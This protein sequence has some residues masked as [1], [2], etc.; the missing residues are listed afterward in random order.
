MHAVLALLLVLSGAAS[1]MYQIAWTRRVMSLTSAT[2]TAQALVVA[3]FM[4]GLGAGAAIAGRSTP[5]LRRPLLAYAACEAVAAIFA[6]LSLPLISALELPLFAV[7]LLLFCAATLI[8]A[9]LPFAIDHAERWIQDPAK[10][11]RTI[12]ILYGSNTLG[13]AFGALTA[14]FATVERFGLHA[15]TLLGAS[16]AGMAA[17]TAVLISRSPPPS[18]RFSPGA[19]AAAKG[20]LIAAA[21]LLGLAGVGA[22]IVYTRLFALILYNTVYAFA[23]VLAAVLIGIA[24]GGYLA[25]AATRAR[26]PIISTTIAFASAA[27]VLIAAS[28]TLV[29]AVAHTDALNASLA[30]GTFAGAGMALL[31]I[32]IPSALVASALPLL[33]AASTNDR[34]AT[35]FGWLYAANTLGGVAGSLLVGFALLPGLGLAPTVALIAACALAAGSILLNTRDR[36]QILLLAF[37]AVTIVVLHFSRDVPKEIYRARIPSDASILDFDEGVVSDAMVTEDARGHRRLWINSAWVAGTGGGHRVLGHLPAL[38]L[39]DPRRALGIALGT[40]QTFA[41][42][43]KHGFASID[44]VEINESV[45]DLSSKW[46]SDANG[47][48]FERPGVRLHHDDGRAFLRST[49]ERYDLII[50]EPLQAWTA[51]TTNLYTREFYR[52]AQRALSPAGVVAQWIPFYGQ[53][54]DDTRAMVRAGAEVFKGASLWLDVADGILLLSDAPFT[55]DPQAIDARIRTRGIASDLSANYIGS[56]AD[57]FAL[58]LAGPEGLGRWTSGARILDDDHPFLEFDAARRIG[59]KDGTEIYASAAASAEDPLRYASSSTVARSILGEA[60]LIRSALFAAGVLPETD[61]HA[62]A[63]ALEHGLEAAPGSL[64]LRARLGAERALER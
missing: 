10:R 62:R 50:L 7:A 58:F 52:E 25:A 19:E 6:A 21:S 42:A 3:L 31:M 45:I 27:A 55:L 49:A 2:A 8:G 22:E 44:C 34:G 4:A 56:D 16:L 5:R 20:R 46:F 36:A 39:A 29:S 33:V 57:L 38:L 13:A 15:T 37:A 64:L 35:R 32:V 63:R 54:L 41:A 11:A 12:G 53:S 1:L 51:G 26:A 59:S 23:S 40:G 9:T 24:L 47:R 28:P 43:Q 60:A 17:L 61:H 14:G 48:L 18:G 30:S